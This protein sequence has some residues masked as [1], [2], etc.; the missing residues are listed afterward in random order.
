MYTVQHCV[1]SSTK[2]F[3]NK[4]SV[5]QTH[6]IT[7]PCQPW[8]IYAPWTLWHASHNKRRSLLSCLKLID[9]F[10]FLFY[11]FV[12]FYHHHHCPVWQWK[13]YSSFI[14]VF[15]RITICTRSLWYWNRSSL[16]LTFFSFF[17]KPSARSSFE[18]GFDFLFFES[19]R[20]NFEGYMGDGR[21]KE[22]EDDENV[23]LCWRNANVTMISIL[24][25][26][27]QNQMHNSSSNNSNNNARPSE[28]SPRAR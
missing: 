12:L 28:R 22:W 8:K 26:L 21:R 25:R 2:F 24:Q 3:C 6:M 7:H 1:R 9:L 20:Q 15:D 27:F 14:W 4:R 10:L 19:N 13:L 11:F 16:L 17:F 23:L 5:K 18:V